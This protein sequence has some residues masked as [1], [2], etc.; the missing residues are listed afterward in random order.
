MVRSVRAVVQ[1]R[2]EE[3]VPVY[4]LTVP[5]PENFALAA[6]IFVHNSK[7][8]ADSLAGSLWG[9][10]R[11]AGQLPVAAGGGTSERE[12]LTISVSGGLVP[13]AEARAVIDGDDLAPEGPAQQTRRGPIMLMG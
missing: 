7:D 5:G 8:C 1:E 3:A 6:G 13:V 2:L 10:C 12:P 4:D 11:L 9:I